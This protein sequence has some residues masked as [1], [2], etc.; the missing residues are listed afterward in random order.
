MAMVY[1]ICCTD[2]YNSYSLLHAVGWLNKV[3]L[4]PLIKACYTP[5]IP[6]PTIRRLISGQPLQSMV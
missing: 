3:I 5:T 2:Y 4:L 6:E 1:N